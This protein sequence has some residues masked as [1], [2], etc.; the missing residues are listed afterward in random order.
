[1][2]LNSNGPSSLSIS[3]RA[4]DIHDSEIQTGRRVEKNINA[5]TMAYVTQQPLPPNR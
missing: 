3:V 5:D 4:V 1:M 2:N